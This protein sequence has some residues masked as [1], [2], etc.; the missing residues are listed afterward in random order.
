MHTRRDWLRSSIGLGGFLL[1]PE[2]VLSS[3][4]R[5]KFN[6]RPLSNFVKLSSNENPY[7]PSEA[8]Q[9]AVIKAFK[10]G[11]RYPYSYSDA[12]AIKL[13]KKHN[14]EPENIII[15]GGSTEGLKITGLTFTQ[16]GGEIIAGKPTFLAMMDFAQQWGAKINWVPV[17]KDKGYDLNAINEQINKNTKLIFLCNPNNPT[18]T[19]IPKNSLK[20]FCVSASKKA[21]VFSDEAYYDFIQTPNYPSMDSLVRDGKNVIVSK[22]FSKIY[23]LAGFRIGY[24]IAPSHLSKKIR[25]NVVAMT[26]VLAIAAAGKALEDQEFYNFSLNK[27]RDGREMITSTLDKL[28]LNYIP[29]NTNFIFFHS[30]KK[31]DVLGEQMLRLGVKIG[32]PFPPFYDWCRISIGTLEEV[33]IFTNALEN[34]YNFS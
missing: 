3:E 18:G 22:T 4:E 25:K 14:V 16:G 23:G 30:G 20:D 13:A 10:N 31:I 32:R 2:L 27:I 26:N 11:C 12:L 19:V 24:L 5:K 17:G 34:V 33:K 7:G 1:A 6:P 8:V 9:K 29:S 28:G 21:I 15:T